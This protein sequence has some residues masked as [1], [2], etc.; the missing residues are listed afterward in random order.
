MHGI[1][2]THMYRVG[3]EVKVVESQRATLKVHQK[4]LVVVSKILAEIP[5]F[6][7]PSSF[8]EKFYMFSPATK[9]SSD[10]KSLGLFIL[11]L[12]FIA[13]LNSYK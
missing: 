3:K 11:F 6:F 8:I 13:L 7:L 4:Y 1:R 9:K 5:L 12:V 2:Y 10:N